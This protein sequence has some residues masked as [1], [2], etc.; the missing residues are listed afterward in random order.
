[1]QWTDIFTDFVYRIFLLKGNLL[2]LGKSSIFQTILLFSE[3]IHFFFCRKSCFLLR[4]CVFLIKKKRVRLPLLLQE[5]NV[6]QLYGRLEKKTRSRELAHKSQCRQI[7][8]YPPGVNVQNGHKSAAMYPQHLFC[9]N[10]YSPFPPLQC[11]VGCVG[12]PSSDFVFN[13]KRSYLMNVNSCTTWKLCV[14]N[15]GRRQDEHKWL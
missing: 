8:K 1:M 2:S 5:A 10:F 9:W 7:R 11:C 12:S 4:K 13:M 6:S 15:I 3:S 14:F